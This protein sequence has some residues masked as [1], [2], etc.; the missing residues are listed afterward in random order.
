MTCNVD[1]CDK[2]VKA[3]GMCNTHYERWRQHGDPLLGARRVP[4]PCSVSDCDNM[5]AGRSLC[6]KHWYRWKVH[7]DPSITLR[8]YGV[9]R[10]ISHN[11]YL[12]VWRPDHP[13]PHSNGYVPEHR[14]VMHDLGFNLDGMQV[15]H[16]DH[17][18]TNNHPSN[19]ALLTMHEHAQLHGAE[20]R[21][22]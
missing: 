15:H 22:A 17:D 1:S 20:R 16:L 7:G 9:K 13:L 5:A 4:Q 3:R 18:K 8:E 21:R 10:R 11:G 14:M 12:H 19:L 6:K 2:R